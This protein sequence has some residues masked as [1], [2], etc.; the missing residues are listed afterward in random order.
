VRFPA[1]RRCETI[2]TWSWATAEAARFLHPDYAAQPVDLL[3]WLE[4]YPDHPEAGRVRALGVT[5]PKRNALLPDVPS[6]SEVV[7]GYQTLGWYSIVAPT[8]T[9][10]EGDGL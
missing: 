5:G 9:P 3:R 4:T 10:T 1:R 6:I 7:P 2:R 8:G